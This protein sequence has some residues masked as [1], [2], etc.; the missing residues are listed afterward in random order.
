[1]YPPEPFK[2]CDSPA[3]LHGVFHQPGHQIREVHA[4]GFGGFG[5]EGGGGE[6]RDGVG[7]QEFLLFRNFQGQVRSD[8]VGQPRYKDVRS[9]PTPAAHLH[10]AI[11]TLPDGRIGSFREIWVEL[12]CTSPRRITPGYL[13]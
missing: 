11:G 12:R 5:E 2:L 7:L 3:P 13:M 8:G 4:G 6:P 10:Q 9:P 1:M